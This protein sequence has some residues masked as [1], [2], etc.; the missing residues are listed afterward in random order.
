MC[1]LFTKIQNN[2]MLKGAYLCIEAD[3]LNFPKKC[4]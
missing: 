1:E 4:T 2:Q 3:G